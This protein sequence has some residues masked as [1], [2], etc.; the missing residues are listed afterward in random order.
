[1][2]NKP[3]KTDEGE[4]RVMRFIFGDGVVRV[5]APRVDE[6][7]AGAGPPARAAVFVREEPAEHLSPYRLPFPFVGA[8]PR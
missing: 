5:V 7:A 4:P 3:G 6:P 1:M 2:L 8:L